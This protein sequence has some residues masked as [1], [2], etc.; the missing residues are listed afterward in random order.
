MLWASTKF[1]HKSAPSGER[2]VSDVIDFA[3]LR[4]VQ[5]LDT[6]AVSTQISYK[7]DPILALRQAL[8]E[9]GKAGDIDPLIS[10]YADDVI[11]MPPNDTTLYGPVRSNHPNLWLT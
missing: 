10:R 4:G 11:V 5:G 1:S 2:S 8:N 7:Q 9:A 6:K 3:R